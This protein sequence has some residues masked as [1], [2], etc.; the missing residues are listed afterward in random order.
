MLICTGLTYEYEHTKKGIYDIDFKAEKGQIVGIIGE[1]GSGK[2]TFFKCLL[3][4]LKPTKGKIFYN[5]KQIGFSKKELRV[6]RQKVNMVLQDPERQIFYNNI[7][8]EIAM[9]PKNLGILQEE[10]DRRIENC[11]KV[12]HG[13]SFINIPVQYLS[14]GQKKRVTL[15]G[16]LAL[17]CDVLLLD[18]PETGLDPKMQNEMM[19][20]LKK[21]AQD[22]KTTI[23]LSHNMELIYALCDSVYVMHSG[24]M[25]DQ[26]DADTVMSNSS[27]LIEAGLTSPIVLRI[28]KYLN[29]SPKELTEK[30][31][32]TT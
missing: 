9:G 11:I 19:T 2:S 31:L 14:F 7:K 4:I 28:A 12:I 22:G 27:I 25:I 15:A 8:D 23:I 26:G 6:Y 29:L 20:I 32:M 13:E 3:G 24:K 16:I 10:I 18:E 17:E 30:A 21:L 1:N 5:Q